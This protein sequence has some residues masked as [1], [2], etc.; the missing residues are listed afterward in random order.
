L[1]HFQ[2]RALKGPDLEGALNYRI[3]RFFKSYFARATRKD[4]S[5]SFQAQGYW[6]LGNWQLY[7]ATGDAKYRDNATRCSE[8][9]LSYQR[10]DGGWNNPELKWRRSMKMVEGTWGSLGLLESYRQTGDTR[11]LTG[12]RK[13]YRFLVCEIGFQRISAE[14]S[15]NLGKGKKGPRVTSLSTLVLRFLAEL[16]HA[17]GQENYLRLSKGLLRFVCEVQSSSGEFQFSVKGEAGGGGRFHFKCFENNAFECLDLMRFYELTSETRALVLVRKVLGFLRMG[18]SEEGHAQFE[19]GDIHREVNS[20]TAVLAQAFARA[21]EL[22]IKGF[23]TVASKAFNHLI[24]K[25]RQDG[26]FDFSERDSFF[27]RDKS[28][29]PRNL[30]MIL[31][32]LLPIPT[33][34]VRRPRTHRSY[35]TKQS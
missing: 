32:R 18:L 23:E 8:F 12:A 16:A 28:S 9:L 31:H 15:A 26:G 20:H 24:E 5:Y 25:Q 22:D 4:N 27:L 21:G 17:S 7:L 2:G 30:A 14:L 11:F 6:I 3:G 34:Q 1:H 10:D 33:K 19:C 13:W 29:Y 35:T